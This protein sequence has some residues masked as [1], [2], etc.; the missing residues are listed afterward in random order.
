[1][2][3]VKRW[4]SWVVGREHLIDSQQLDETSCAVKRLMSMLLRLEPE[5]FSS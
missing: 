3:Y 1:M 5:F 2:L 4:N